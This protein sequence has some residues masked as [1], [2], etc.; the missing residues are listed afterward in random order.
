MEARANWLYRAFTVK[1][2]WEASL[3]LG[4]AGLALAGAGLAWL[5]WAPA[6]RPAA[7]RWLGGG[8]RAARRGARRDLLEGGIRVAGITLR[9]FTEL[10][11]GLLGIGLLRQSLEGWRRWRAGVAERHLAERDWARLLLGLGAV[12]FLLSLGPVVALGAFGARPIDEG[13]YAWLW[14]HVVLFRAIR[15]PTRIGILVIVAGALLAALGVKWLLA[16]PRR[17]WGRVL[18]GALGLA[19][20]VEYARMPLP[21][22]QEDPI[23]AVDAVLKADRA[24][25]AV[26]EWP[27]NVQ[28]VDVD[29]MFRSLDHGKRVVNGLSG[30]VPA[31]SG[32]CPSC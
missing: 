25:V 28:V 27:P 8:G 18:V 20:V 13:L 4:V 23:R 7:D 11:V 19:L 6:G 17:P 21:Y 29:A 5:R 2:A 9:P 1:R 26:L 22:A 32:T 16:Q 24:D 15:G 31:A 14:P 10:G 12:A 30:F 3:F